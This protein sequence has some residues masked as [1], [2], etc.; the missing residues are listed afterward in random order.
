M[1]EK[2][3]TC[4]DF[5]AVLSLIEAVETAQA[6]SGTEAQRERKGGEHLVAGAPPPRA[7][8]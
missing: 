2:R 8:L 5:E 1:Q 4:Q 3:H 6:A 7:P